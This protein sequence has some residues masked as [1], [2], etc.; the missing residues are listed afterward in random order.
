MQGGGEAW[1]GPGH[2][3]EGQ[4]GEEE[5]LLPLPDGSNGELWDSLRVF[6]W[7]QGLAV[8]EPWWCVK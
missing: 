3:A 5:K 8:A 7:Q 6:S 1:S 4:Q 2:P